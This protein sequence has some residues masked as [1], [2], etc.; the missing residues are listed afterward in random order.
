MP[1]FFGQQAS[2]ANQPND[3]H[4]RRQ[5]CDRIN[6]GMGNREIIIQIQSIR[7]RIY[8]KAQV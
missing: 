1:I 7:M 4:Q 5:G 2:Y 6:Q 3:H 8:Q